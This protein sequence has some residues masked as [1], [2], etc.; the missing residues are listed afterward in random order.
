MRQ[1]LFLRL[2]AILCGVAGATTLLALVFQER[3]LARDLEHVAEERLLASAQSATLLIEDH[4]RAVAERYLAISGTPQFRAHLE[5]GDAPTLEFYAHELL[6]S[7]GASRVVFLDASDRVVAAVGDTELDLT[8]LLPSEPALV[9]VGDL[10]HVVVSLPLET[11]GVPLGRLVAAQPVAAATLER[12]SRTCGAQLEVVGMGGVGGDLSRRVE[13]VLGGEIHAVTSLAPE[14]AAAARAR[15]QLLTSGLIALL[16]AF[17][18]SFVLSRGLVR[19]IVALR[20][21]ALRVGAGDL[22]TEIRSTRSDEIGDVARAFSDMAG[23]LR[24]TLSEVSRAA[25]HVEATSAEIEAITARL[26]EVAARQVGANREAGQAMAHIDERTRGLSSTAE[27]SART[28]HDAIEGSSTSFQSL[29]SSGER[30]VSNATALSEQ[31]DEI[32]R[33]MQEMTQNARR[34]E[35]HREELGEAAEATSQG[36]VEMAASAR[37]VNVNAEH[38]ARL[39]QS[40]IHLSEQGRQRVLETM[41]GMEVIRDTIRD[42]EQVIHNLGGGVDRIGSVLTVI[43]DVTEETSLLALNASI[44][45]AQAGEH[46]RAFAIVADEMR[47]LAD[48]VLAGTKEIEALIRD[49]QGGSA[50]AV[51]AIA[52]GSQSVDSGVALAAEAGNSLDGITAAARES[53]DRM[54]EVVGAT[55]QQTR[56]AASIVD[57]MQRVRTGVEQLRALGLEH[58]RSG[59][60]ILSASVALADVARQLRDTT[61]AQTGGTGEI[62]QNIETVRTSVASI[63]TALQEQRQACLDALQLLERERPLIDANESSA[64]GLADSVRK[65]RP[66]AERLR[67]QIRRFQV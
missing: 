3:S 57:Q 13:S 44:I 66:S 58:D 31:S 35:H 46:G 11:R 21:A 17:A 40:V 39:S 15:G 32:S 14:R 45:A 54:A 6:R 48:R 5:A 18:A 59:G 67:A 27:R 33:A 49:I 47:A 41:Q 16:T 24:S 55:T 20:D 38:T 25:D 37:Q 22:T 30:L 34:V 12:W 26:T 50:E 52:R 53:S 4:V 61:G 9:R 2:L 7:Q 64:A 62:G 60:A 42:A 63:Q 65:L 28:L 43:D 51:R 19:P 23:S 8:T 29:R 1:R 56:T 10:L 36:M